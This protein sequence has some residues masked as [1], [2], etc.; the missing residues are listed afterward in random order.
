MRR[1]ELRLLLLLGCAIAPFRSP[2][3]ARADFAD[4]PA[5][6]KRKTTSVDAPTPKLR[7]AITRPSKFANSEDGV[8]SLAT[9]ATDRVGI[10]E[11][12]FVMGS[13]PEEILD[14]LA[15]CEAM[16]GKKCL[17][18]IFADEYAPH[19]VYLD[20]FSIDRR[21]V[22]VARYE[23]CVAAGICAAPQLE[24]GGGRF[25]HPN[26]PVTMVSWNEATQYCAWIGGAL[27][28]EA[29]WER[30]AR[31]L[32]ARTFAWGNVF[33]RFLTNGGRD[34]LVGVVPYED[35]DGF[36][37]LAPV[38]SFPEGRTPDKIDD[39][40]GNVEEWVRDLYAPEYPPADMA[41]PEGPGVGDERVVR[42]GSYVSGKMFLRAASRDGA[43]P[44]ERRTFRGFRCAYRA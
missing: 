25:D 7:P 37:E 42:G 8:V 5:A 27:P 4:P 29:Q 44:S 19:S 16:L 18:R 39:L 2:H 36:L 24:A 23:R 35:K 1:A 34:S 20:P 6:A 41:N 17:E 13:T 15:A 21:E 28:T 38:G 43:L 9:P 11:G 30:A 26:F 22:T 10:T 32:S 40:A 3:D 33:N 31:G 14:V 12:T